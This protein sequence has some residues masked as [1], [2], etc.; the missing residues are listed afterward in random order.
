M[1]GGG[2]PGKLADCSEKDPALCE[3]FLVEGDSAGG[4]AKMGRDRTF[5]AILPLKGKILNVEKAR[6]DKI[7]GHLEIQVMV[8]AFGCGF[9]RADDEDGFDIKKLRYHK[10][11]IMTDA[12]VDGAHIRTLLLTF[13]FRH[14]PGLI[15]NGHVYI[16][17]PPL[18]R[19]TCGKDEQYVY[20]DEEKDRIVAALEGKKCDVQRYKGLGEMNPDQL[21]NTTMDPAKRS[22]LS[23]KLD[24]VVEA[25][26]VFTMLMGEEVEPRRK[27]IEE[28]ASKVQNLDI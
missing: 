13:L 21:A 14:M 25:D 5:Q 28:N 20:S 4:S 24:D 10:I 16:A 18:Y 15:E 19:I 8:Q 9:G 22:L 26:R 11:I 1:D 17:Q 7:L 12:D 23:V 27:F 2:L 6:V 3:V